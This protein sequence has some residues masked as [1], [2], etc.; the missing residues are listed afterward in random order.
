MLSRYIFKRD[1]MKEYVLDFEK[2]AMD[3]LYGGNVLI[4][5]DIQNEYKNL[6]IEEGE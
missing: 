3:I 2:Y 6:P 4:G 5:K 1:V